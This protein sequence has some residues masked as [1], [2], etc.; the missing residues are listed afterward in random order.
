MNEAKKQ[1]A[2]HKTKFNVTAFVTAPV[3]IPRAGLLVVLIVS[4]ILFVFLKPLLIEPT[5]NEP[6]ITIYAPLNFTPSH[7]YP[8]K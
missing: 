1:A 2:E 3:E 6:S 7:I 4:V 5:E 8:A